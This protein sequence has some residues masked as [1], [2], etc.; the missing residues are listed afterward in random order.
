M[1]F[2]DGKIRKLNG[3]TYLGLGISQKQKNR[4]LFERTVLVYFILRNFKL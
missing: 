4:S 1:D 3:F 2:P